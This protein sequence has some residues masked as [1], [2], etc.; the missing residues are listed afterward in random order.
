MSFEREQS[1]PSTTG[2]PDPT[3]VSGTQVPVGA[4]TDDSDDLAPANAGV[5]APPAVSGASGS[6]TDTVKDQGKQVAQGAAESGKQ[7][8]GVAADQA[9]SVA[10]EARSQVGNLVDEA[11]SQLGSQASTQQQNLAGWVRSIAEELKGM[12]DRSSSA[13]G[14]QGTE[15]GAATNLVHQASQRVHSAADWL[16]NH[17]PSDL[18]DEVSRFARRR[19]GAFLALAALGGLVAGRLTRGLTAGSGE[20]SGQEGGTTGDVRTVTSSYAPRTSSYAAPTTSYAAPASSYAAPVAGDEWAGTPAVGEEQW[21][22][23]EEGTPGYPGQPRA[24]G[25][26]LR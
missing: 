2:D 11:K 3:G 5:D 24:T 7:V 17:E 13:G 26:E 23:E 19:P 15:Q 9:K 1:R 12:L 10:S 25:Q 22:L 16:E 6:T 18:L 14:E 20:S 4:Y 8:A 21:P